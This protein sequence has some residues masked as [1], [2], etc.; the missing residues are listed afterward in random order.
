MPRKM[1]RQ[2]F[3][4]LLHPVDNARREFRFAKIAAHRVRQLPPEFIAALR[5]NPFIADDGVGGAVEPVDGGNM[6][7]RRIKYCSCP[8]AEIQPAPLP[9]D[10]QYAWR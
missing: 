5:M 4:G 9:P 6:A 1:L 3:A 10:H 8:V 7:D 2:Q